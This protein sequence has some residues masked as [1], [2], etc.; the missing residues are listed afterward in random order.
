MWL[1]DTRESFLFLLSLRTLDQLRELLMG[2]P[3]RNNPFATHLF[4]VC[5]CR[6]TKSYEYRYDRYSR[7]SVRTASNNLLNSLEA[8]FFVHSVFVTAISSYRSQIHV[9]KQAQNETKWTELC[10]VNSIVLKWLL[11]PQFLALHCQVRGLFSG[12]AFTRVGSQGTQKG[13]SRVRGP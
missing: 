4:I 12:W 5:T 3:P 2:I 13:L 7:F 6:Q 10:R 1:R 11:T 9:R 8:L